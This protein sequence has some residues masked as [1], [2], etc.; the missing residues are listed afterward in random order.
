MP[1]LA[2]TD[3]QRAQIIIAASGVPMRWRTRFLSAVE[4][5][6]LGSPNPPTAVDVT[7]ACAAAKR[8]ICV[9]ISVPS[10]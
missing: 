10:L 9:G 8:A 5:L 4:G 1:A 2:L 6:L 7:R 3:E